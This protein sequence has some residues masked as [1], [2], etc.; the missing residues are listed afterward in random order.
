MEDGMSGQGE[1]EIYILSKKKPD[2]TACTAH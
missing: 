2:L 1:L